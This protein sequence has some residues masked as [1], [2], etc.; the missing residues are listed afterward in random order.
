[1]VVNPFLSRSFFRKLS[2]CLGVVIFFYVF[3]LEKLHGQG[4]GLPSKYWG[5]GFGNLREFSG[6]R[7]NFRDSGI[8]EINGINITLWQPKKDNS[9]AVVTGLSLGL[10]PGG[11]TMR[12]VQIGVLGVAAE[13]DVRG[14]AIGL[15]GVGCGGDMVGVNI[16][17]LGAGAG[18]SVRGLNVGLLGVGAGENLEGINIGGLGGGAGGDVK[19][20]NVGLLGMGAGK[21]LM[22]LTVA[23]LGAGA[24][25]ILKGI[26]ICGLGAGAPTIRGVTIAGLGVGGVDVKGVTLAFGMIKIEDDGKLSGFSASACNYVKGTQE[27]ISIGIFNYAFRLRGIQIGLIN[28]VRDNPKPLRVL[29]VFNANF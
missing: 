23:G 1:M 29:P 20:L 25:E 6:L 26:T 21:R 28:V 14:I 3:G 27:G 16:G 24:G 4:V 19:G 5:I 9:Q 13:R 11:G 10:M 18:G 15:L 2:Q 17:G 8:R 22:G 12:G 7:F